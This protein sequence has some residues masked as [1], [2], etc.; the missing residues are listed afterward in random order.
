MPAAAIASR[1]RRRADAE[2]S[3]STRSIMPVALASTIASLPCFQNTSFVYVS[4]RAP[5]RAI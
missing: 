3:R 4:Q 2:V 1:M 5:A